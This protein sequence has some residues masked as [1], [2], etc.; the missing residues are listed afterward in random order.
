MLRITLN[1]ETLVLPADFSMSLTIENP[2]LVPDKIP[3]PFTTTF[4]LPADPVNLRLFEFPNR[5]NSKNSFKEYDSAIFFGPIRILKGVLVAQKF[6]KNIKAYFRGV[7]I[8]DAIT[9]Q[10]QNVQMDQYSFGSGGSYNPSFTDPG[11]FAYKYK[12]FI[13][14]TLSGT[15]DFV[16]APV[17]LDGVEWP[18][19]VNDRMPTTHGYYAS[20]ELYLNFFN[21]RN[22]TYTITQPGSATPEVHTVIFPMPFVYKLIDKI[23]GETIMDNFFRTGELSK[24]VLVTTYHP[25]F[26]GF[27]MAN[28]SGILLDGDQGNGEKYFFLNSFLPA[29]QGN[30]FFKEI[31]KMFC[32]SLYSSNGKFRIVK[33]KDIICSKESTDWT[34]KLI[35]NLSISKQKGQRYQY[36]YSSQQTTQKSNYE[37]ENLSDLNATTATEDNEDVY[38]IRSLKA[39]YTKKLRKKANTADKNR[40]IYECVGAKFSSQLESD[41]NE[42]FDCT[43]TTEPLPLTIDEYWFENGNDGGINL[44]TWAVPT[45]KLDNRMVRS[46]LSNVLIYQGLT[47]TFTPGDQYPLLSAYNVDAFGNKM[48]DLTLNWEGDNGLL[49]RFHAEFKDW[50]QSDKIR[51]SGTFLLS[52]LDLKK[53]DLSKK[54]DVQGKK[55]FIEKISVYLTHSTIEPAEVDLIES[56]AFVDQT[57]IYVRKEYFAKNNCSVAGQKG[58]LV[59]YSVTYTSTISLDDAKHQA[60]VQEAKFQGEGQAWANAQGSCIVPREVIATLEASPYV[61]D[62]PMNGTLEYVIRASVRLNAPVS[63][64]LRFSCYVELK[65]GN[66]SY[67][68]TQ[69]DITI[70]ANSYQN[71]G[72]TTMNVFIPISDLH[73]IAAGN[74]ISVTPNVVDGL[75]I[76]F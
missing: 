57:Y 10:L 36:G 28:Q 66:Q 13:F 55:F 63:R 54:L 15:G 7:V 74:I 3:T 69:I 24:L 2:L 29:I 48:G 23:F 9:K 61:L 16:A 14:K 34:S 67:L 46:D 62:Y 58:T 44:L 6:D 26:T 5:L 32:G 41:E 64:D 49:N 4:D 76:V 31:L 42:T 53:L 38:W 8:N 17:R 19:L 33:N 39:S 65:S 72:Q 30:D 60:D 12:E 75:T 22:K 20:Q 40:Y 43:V 47:N 50:I 71:S 56:P 18:Y 11:G 68:E 73:P 45:L 21:A 52:A 27:T 59:P 37:F 25:N 51:A 70:S 1:N 35:D